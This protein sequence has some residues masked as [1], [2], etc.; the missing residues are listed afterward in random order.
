MGNL[1]RI[2]LRVECVSEFVAEPQGSQ[3]MK[4]RRKKQDA[5]R[6]RFEPKKASSGATPTEKISCPTSHEFTEHSARLSH[7]GRAVPSPL[8]VSQ[9]SVLPSPWAIRRVG[10]KTRGVC[11]V[12][13][14]WWHKGRVTSHLR[15]FLLRQAVSSDAPSRVIIC[16]MKKG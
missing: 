6:L 10:E 12:G 14:E 3:K 13:E 9:K 5:E 16:E 4:R 15:A 1:S 11:R 2:I 7:R 8:L